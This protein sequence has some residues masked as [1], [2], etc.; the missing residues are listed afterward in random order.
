MSATAMTSAASVLNQS[1]IPALRRLKVRETDTTI[2]VT[3]Q[4]SSYYLKQLAQEFLIPLLEGRE[5][6]NE[7]EVIPEDRKS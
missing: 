7:V 3:G 5:L 6:L 4:V 1:S 2:H